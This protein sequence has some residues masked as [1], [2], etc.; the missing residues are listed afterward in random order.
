MVITVVRIDYRLALTLYMNLITIRSMRPNFLFVLFHK[1][2][3]SL[4][5]LVYTT[6]E[7]PESR[8]FI[9]TAQGRT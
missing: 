9:S 3:E 6:R 7:D 8:L 1:V 4:K 2:A 5:I